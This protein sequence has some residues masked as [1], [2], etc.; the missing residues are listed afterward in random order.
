MAEMAAPPAPAPAGR[1]AGA[2][3]SEA[4]AAFYRE[5][6]SIAREIRLLE[7]KVQRA[8]MASKLTALTAPPEALTPPA[9]AA[10]PIAA[11]VAAAADELVNRPP[12]FRLISV[13]GQPLSLNADVMVNGVRVSIKAGEVLP[14]NWT[15]SAITRDA[16]HLARGRD[17]FTMKLGG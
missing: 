12:P 1:S 16:L 9:L 6:A 17:K 2:K 14:D 5:E 7:L 4:E 3:V 13:W 10:L 8:E 15:V 11:T